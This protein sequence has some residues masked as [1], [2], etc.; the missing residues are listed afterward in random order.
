ME[1]RN[2]Q[3]A[4]KEVAVVVAVTALLTCI[5]IY[6]ARE[7]IMAAAI[8]SAPHQAL[9]WALAAEV[10]LPA[11]LYA[12]AFSVTAH[13]VRGRDGRFRPAA[14]Y[15]LG[16]TAVTLFEAFQIH[17]RVHAG[18]VGA[19]LD[20]IARGLDG[21]LLHLVL[22]APAVLALLA[23]LAVGA[24]IGLGTTWKSARNQVERWRS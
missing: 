19:H 5:A 23:S 22:F 20:L 18:L 7:S 4:G 10:I 13:G 2:P 21:A 16:A 6:E 15:I 14:L 24:G 1:R 8:R 3:F 11:G 12:R 17:P 9:I